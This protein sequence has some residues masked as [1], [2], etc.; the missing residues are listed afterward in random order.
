M[1]VVQKLTKK[2]WRVPKKKFL[3]KYANSTVYEKNGTQ[4]PG[5]QL[6]CKKMC[7][8][9]ACRSLQYTASLKQLIIYEFMVGLL[10]KYHDKRN[11]TK[12]KKN[13]ALKHIS[14]VI[15]KATIYRV[16]PFAF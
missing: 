3:C 12:R 1:E 7:F 5:S 6:R 13:W 4:I 8:I 2:L 14:E 10:Y 15:W 11:D 9:T 16:D